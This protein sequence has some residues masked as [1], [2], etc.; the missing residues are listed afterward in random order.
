M[1]LIRDNI[2][3]PEDRWFLVSKDESYKYLKE[4]LQEEIQELIDSDYK[5]IYEYADV[6]ETLMTLAKY[7]KKKWSDIELARNIKWKE[8]GGF[9]NKILKD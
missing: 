5:D 9:S 7:N 8:R 3:I 6:L 2:P 4:K 1:K